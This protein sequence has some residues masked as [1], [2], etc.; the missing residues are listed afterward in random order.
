MLRSC[1]IRTVY[2]SRGA[3]LAKIDVAQYCRA[4]GI[5]GRFIY[6]L[7]VL[8]VAGAC[9][10]PSNQKPGPPASPPV[11]DRSSSAADGRA[12]KIG[13]LLPLTGPMA[14]YGREVLQGVELAVGQASKEA[15]Q[16]SVQVI[17]RDA[18]MNGTTPIQDHLSALLHDAHPLAVIGPLVSQQVEAVAAVSD[19]AKIPLITPTATLP[20]VR[21]LSPYLFSTGLTYSLQ[22]EQI[23]TYA[24]G[25][26]GYRRF[27]VIH[28]DSGYGRQLAHFFAEE[29]RRRGG[30][31][32]DMESYAPE[33]TDFAK[34]VTRLKSAAWRRIQPD[35]R[36]GQAFTSGRPQEQKK[37]RTPS[38]RSL[39]AIY[40]PGGFREATM[41]AAQLRFQDVKVR[42]LG[43]NAWHSSDLAHFPDKSIQGGV[44][45]DNFF[46]E[47][48]ASAVREF[49]VAY[50]IRYHTE[51]TMFAAQ[52]YEATQVILAGIRE[53]V[54]SGKR[55]RSYLEQADTLPTLLGPTSFNDKGV[56]NRTLLLIQVGEKGRLEQ[57]R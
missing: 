16:A 14:A 38:R 1:V 33:E 34:Q 41:I 28:P 30:E 48:R 17:V 26:L 12:Y 54:T 5:A 40:L 7:I 55:L 44:F 29:V 6:F 39:D 53:G 2:Y 35:D 27:A 23:T 49:V 56:L 9:Q 42:L 57:V 46:A 32:V 18:A 45:T 31:I 24:M 15:G 51:P 11:L 52:G 37:Y 25:R 47:S 4:S 50:R 10:A 3:G 8:L 20:D 43:S 13:A 22:A 36:S 21:R 19:E